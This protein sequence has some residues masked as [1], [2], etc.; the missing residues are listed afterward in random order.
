MAEAES[1]VIVGGGP[2]GLGA[3]IAARSRGARAIVI[4]RCGGPVDKACG[5]G[6][7]PNAVARLQQMGVVTPEWGSHPFRGIRYIDAT[8]GVRVSAEADFS[9]GVGLGVRRLALSEALRA[10]AQALGVEFWERTEATGYVEDATGVTVRTTSGT[11]RGKWLIAADGLHS[12]VRKWAGFKTTTGPARRLGIRQHFTQPPWA[13][14]VE[15]WWSDQAEAYVTPA[16]PNRVGVA[17][18]W[19]GRDQRG[20]MEMFL[21]LFPE[22]AGRLGPPESTLRG[23]GPFDVRVAAQQQGRMLLVGDAAGY[24]DALTGEGIALGLEQAEAAVARCLR[25]AP[26]GW[27]SEWTTLTRRHRAFTRLLLGVAA[28]PWLR[29]MVIRGLAAVPAAF[30]LGL[31]VGSGGQ[32]ALPGA[33]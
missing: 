21:K 6:L 12:Q 13:D 17:F 3:A 14:H 29:R 7:M 31:N 20:D 9:Q 2:T 15:V 5:E 22:L 32:R 4:E 27:T 30:Q 19:R 33:R 24:V 8:S 23:A 16:G 1:F 18:L 26:E 10:R 11:A 25:N 28:R